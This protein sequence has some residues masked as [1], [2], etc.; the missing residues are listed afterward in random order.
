MLSVSVSMFSDYPIVSSSLLSTVLRNLISNSVKFT[1]ER[2]SVRVEAS[3][4]EEPEGEDKVFNNGPEHR[5]R[6]SA[7]R[8][9]E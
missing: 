5:L 1:P 7:G 4:F 3:F 6:Q 2:G 9:L 8:F